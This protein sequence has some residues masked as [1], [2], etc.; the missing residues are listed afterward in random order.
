M[1]MLSETL[2]ESVSARYA[3]KQEKVLLSSA[4]G[5]TETVLS[6]RVVHLF[7]RF[8]QHKKKFVYLPKGL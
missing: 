7:V 1:K 5:G 6:G 8:Q 2:R 4:P 3:V